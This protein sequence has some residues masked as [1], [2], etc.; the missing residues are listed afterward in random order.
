MV[1]NDVVDPSI[2]LAWTLGEVQMEPPLQP[3]GP[4]NACVTPDFLVLSLATLLT[5]IPVHDGSFAKA[6]LMNY[7]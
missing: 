4:K 2:H 3:C 5:P 7:S 6:M 1:T